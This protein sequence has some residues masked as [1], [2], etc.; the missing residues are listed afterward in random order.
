MIIIIQTFLL[1]IFFIYIPDANPK[2]PHTLPHF[3]ALEFPCTEA[4]KV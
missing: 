3:L 1:G 4:Y 2:V